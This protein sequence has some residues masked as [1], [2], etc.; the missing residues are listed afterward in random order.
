MYRRP[1]ERPTGRKHYCSAEHRAQAVGAA[2][3]KPKRLKDC[4]TCGRAFVQIGKGRQRLFCS[5]P[6][7]GISVR[8]PTVIKNGYALV[9]MPRHPRA[10]AYGYVRQHR[11]VMESSI[12]RPLAAREVVHHRNGIKTDN[13]IENLELIADNA[14]HIRSHHRHRASHSNSK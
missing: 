12:G 5:L 10:D 14:T 1:C 11:L 7:W 4:A 6:C 3:R 13:R 9:L 2:N 8:K